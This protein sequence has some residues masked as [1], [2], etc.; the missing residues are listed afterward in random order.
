MPR[1]RGRAGPPRGG[2]ALVVTLE[3]DDLGWAGLVAHDCGILATVHSRVSTVSSS[4]RVADWAGKL[5]AWDL[6]ASRGVPPSAV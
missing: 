5:D 1:V 6:A 4:P 2:H 3:G